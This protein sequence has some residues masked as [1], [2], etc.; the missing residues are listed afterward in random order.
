MLVH[1]GTRESVGIRLKGNIAII[2]E[3]IIH[4]GPFHSDTQRGSACRL[5]D[6]SMRT[7]SH[8]LGPHVFLLFGT[9]PFPI[10]WDRTV[11]TAAGGGGAVVRS[12]LRSRGP[13][14]AHCFLGPY[15]G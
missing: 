8:C 1:K 11:F 2:D 7:V 9:A 14:G 15:L 6:A 3:V 5:R 13:R 12:P 10:V 4:G